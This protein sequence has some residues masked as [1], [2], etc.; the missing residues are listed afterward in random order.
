MK[1]RLCIQH[2]GKLLFSPLSN[3]IKG[4]D[5]L[6]CC[7][8]SS[9]CCVRTHPKSPLFLYTPDG[10]IQLLFCPYSSQTCWENKSSLSQILFQ[11]GQRT[12]TTSPIR[13]GCVVLRRWRRWRHLSHL[14]LFFWQAR[15]WEIWLPWILSAG[16]SVLE[17]VVVALRLCFL[18]S[19]HSCSPSGSL[20]GERHLERFLTVL[21]GPKMG[22]N[23]SCD[24]LVVQNQ[25]CLEAWP[26]V[27][28][29]VLTSNFE[30]TIS[31]I[32][33]PPA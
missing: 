22:S 19:N 31:F 29:L 15:V 26:E 16:W 11:P 8:L 12:E 7:W 23:S 14:F 18:S 17:R 33:N 27:C 9:C 3:S 10:F 6:D 24:F 2:Q 20:R 4:S 30:S 25:L 32:L 5:G 28:L 13:C 1:R 21:Y